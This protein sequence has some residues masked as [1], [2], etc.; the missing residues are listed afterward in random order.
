[1]VSARLRL[2]LAGAAL[3]AIS[4]AL[5]PWLAPNPPERQFSTY[6]FAPPMPAHIVADGA[7]VRPYVYPLRLED[8]LE[9]RYVEDQSRRMTLRWFRPSLVSVPG[10]EPWFPFG[11]DGLGRDVFSRVLAGARLSLGLAGLATVLAL[12]IGAA[13]GALAGFAN[14]WLDEGLMRIADLVLVLPAI[15]VVLALRGALPLVLGT[16]QVFGAMVLVLGLVGWPSVARG[17]RGIFITER[18]SEYAESARAIGGSPLRVAV[19]HLL[20]AA[21]GFLAVQA[22]ILIPAFV[23]AEA[24]ISFA[25]LGFAPPAASWGVMLQDAAAVQTAADAP[26]L[27]APGLAIV[28]TILVVHLAAGGPQATRR[29]LFTANP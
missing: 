18:G 9:R 19:R 1:M 21:R 3:I 6:P 13:V 25:G 27:L 8:P 4:A 15:Y 28:V 29:G 20:P 12:V 2:G 17:V 7:F 5:A 10:S 26:W 22:T 16:A 11:S 14:G 24:T 23:L